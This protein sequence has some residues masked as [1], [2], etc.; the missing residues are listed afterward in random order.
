MPSGLDFTIV[1]GKESVSY[2][3]K[4]LRFAVCGCYTAVSGRKCP[5]YKRLYIYQLLELYS[6]CDYTMNVH[7]LKNT[8]MEQNMN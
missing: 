2:Y 8:S 1:G 4:N 3:T 6:I 7:I 5:L